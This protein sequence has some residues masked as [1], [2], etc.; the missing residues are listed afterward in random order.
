MHAFSL[1]LIVRGARAAVSFAARPAGAGNRVGFQSSNPGRQQMRLLSI[2]AVILGLSGWTTAVAGL[3][4]LGHWPGFPSSEPMAVAVS[5]STGFLFMPKTAGLVSCDISDPDQ[6]RFLEFLQLPEDPDQ[7]PAVLAS[8]VREG[9]LHLSGNR[10][11]AANRTHFWIVDVGDPAGM[12]L[13][14]NAVMP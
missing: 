11:C 4:Q 12:R 8:W 5:G 1:D 7:V 13:L 10:L 3:T 2:S 9:V 6:P 14:G